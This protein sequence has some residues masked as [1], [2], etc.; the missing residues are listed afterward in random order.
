LIGSVAGFEGVCD[1]EPCDHRLKL[2]LTVIPVLGT[3][4]TVNRL[5][6]SGISLVKHQD[7]IHATMPME[8]TEDSARVVAK[9]AQNPA[10]PA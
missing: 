7:I 9:N 1:F 10:S 5:Q 4:M 8:P 6:F 2:S 3:G